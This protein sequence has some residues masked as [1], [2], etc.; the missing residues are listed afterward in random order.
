[1]R[2]PQEAL[3]DA[4]ISADPGIGVPAAGLVLTLRTAD[5]AAASRG[6]R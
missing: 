5:L 4:G 6:S 1:M 3:R 2:T